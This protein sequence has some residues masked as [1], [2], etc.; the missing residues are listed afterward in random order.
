MKSEP[1][2]KWLA[3]GFAVLFAV[4]LAVAP[5][6]AQQVTG[7]LGSAS[8]TTTLEGNQLPPPPFGGVINESARDSRPWWPPRVV[9]PKGA[10]NVLLIMTDDQG[11]GVSGT[12][13]G[14]I[15]TPA[16]DRVAKAGL[17]YTQFHS[18][19]LCSPTRA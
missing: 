4:T 10:P 2:Q 15:P 19:A 14:V 11:Y 8:A 16:L 1:R 13:G 6:T 17:R 9:P 5:A 18:T 7:T 3:D 12:F